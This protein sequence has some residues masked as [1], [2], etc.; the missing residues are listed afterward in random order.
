MKKA[1]LLTTVFLAVFW[2]S[3][4][5]KKETSDAGYIP[6]TITDVLLRKHTAA[7]T[8][9]LLKAEALGPSVSIAITTGSRIICAGTSVTFTATPSG[10]GPQVLYQWKKN[11]ITVGTTIATYSDAI[12]ADGDVITCRMYDRS[13]S[14]TT[15]S[16]P[17]TMSVNA[18]V[19]PT[20]TIAA[21]P[22]NTITSRTSVTFTATP[23]NGGTPVYQ[24]KKN[25]TNVGTNSATYTDATLA[26]NDVI[27]C[28]LT[29]NAD[30]IAPTVANSTPIQMVVTVTPNVTIAA[31][32]TLICVGTSVTFTATPTNGGASPSYQWKKNGLNVGTNSLTY[33]DATL[34]NIDVIRCVMTS[35]DPNASPISVTS[36]P[37][38]MIVNPSPTVNAIANRTVCVGDTTSM[39][40]LSGS[41][42]QYNWTNS[43]PNIGLAAT[44]TGSIASFTAVNS[45]N[46]PITATITVTP[47]RNNLI[48]YAYIANYNANTVSVINTTLNTVVATIPVGTNPHGV[49][50]SPNNQ[51][52][53]VANHGSNT[54][55]VIDAATNTILTT[56]PVSPNPF[57]LAFSPTGAFLYVSNE[58]GGGWVSVI[59][60]VSHAVVESFNIAG[61]RGIA[62]YLDDSHVYIV[63]DGWNGTISMLNRDANLI[64]SIWL[65]APSGDNDAI[66]P[67]DLVSHPNRNLIYVSA[68]LENAVYIVD[69]TTNLPIGSIPMGI[70]PLGLSLNANGS[71]LYVTNYQSNNVSVLNT[72]TNT[73]VSTIPVG[74]NPH[75]ISVSA[76]GRYIYVVNEGS[77]NVSVIDTATY[78]VVSTIAVGIKPAS[79]G[80]F[81][82]AN[83]STCEGS[84]T[85]FSIT[86]QPLPNATIS[87]ATPTTFCQGGNVVLNANAGNGLSYQWNQNGNAIAA[88]ANAAMFTATNTGSYTVVVTDANACMNTSNPT[89]VIVNTLPNTTI[90]HATPTTFCQGGNVVL[91][92]PSTAGLT[93]QWRNNG[94]ALNLTDRSY[95]AT[96][97]GA[98]SVSVTDA[99]NCTTTSPATTVVVNPMPTPVLSAS[100]NRTFC[101]GD[102]V[103]LQ[104]SGGVNYQWSH[105]T[106]D[107][108]IWLKNTGIYTVTVANQWGCS[109]SIAQQITVKPL[110]IA[111]SSASGA[112]TFCQGEQVVLN[113]NIGAGL[114]YQW[115]RNGTLI[116]NATNPN[117]TA[118]STGLYTVVV[119]GLN[120]CNNTSIPNSV[121]LNALPTATITP[122]SATTFCQ[123]GNVVLNANS[124]T[125]LRYQ[126]RNNGTPING[127]TNANYTTS[128]AGSYTVF[129]TNS[130]NC[131]S[132]SAAN[133]LIINELP[134]ASIMNATNILCNGDKSTLTVGGTGGL[135]P[136]QYN[137]NGGTY[138]NSNLFELSAGTFNVNVRD[139]NG[140]TS[141]NTALTLT[142]PNVLTIATP[143]AVP[144]NCYDGFTDLQS[145]ANGGTTPYQYSLTGF[146]F[147]NPNQFSV[148]GGT[149]QMVVRDA[150]G[151]RATSPL[152]NVAR[153]ADLVLTTATNPIKCWGDT[154]HSMI[155]VANAVSP[156]QYTVN[157]ISQNNNLYKGLQM[158]NYSVGVVDSRGCTKTTTFTI[159]Q[160]SLLTGNVQVDTMICKGKLTPLVVTA[161]GGTGN[162][163][164]RLNAGAFQNNT[165]M[166][167]AG[168]QK[169]QIRDANQCLHTLPTVMVE[170]ATAKMGELRNLKINCHEMEMRIYP[171]PVVDVMSVDFKIAQ[172]GVVKVLVYNALGD[173]IAHEDYKNIEAGSYTASWDTANWASDMVRVCL[174]VDGV[175]VQVTSVMIVH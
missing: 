142:Q 36:L 45:T 40:A 20:V 107:S 148:Q 128:T 127:A 171:N 130:N 99:N 159:T 90:T 62:A 118:N 61:A 77:N 150:N 37:I 155:Q 165:F 67:Y 35:N 83:R 7:T 138:Q 84:S 101:Q 141:L 117:Y 53:Y 154:T 173:L 26:M 116:P 2:Q 14:F 147:Q 28:E 15:T 89:S 140:C 162:I 123:G 75:G 143:T 166:V 168:E 108:S 151:C 38:T 152:Y 65:G 18:I 24:W 96:A 5:A 124:G 73:V 161:T 30:C 51:F 149:Y 57:K 1:F 25:N 93:Y 70:Q 115:Q 174:E 52:V 95:V 13:N 63:N 153:P 72:V 157:G 94:N 71:R 133:T 114:T 59:E 78:T 146:V 66:G 125:G 88:N 12:L 129:V 156:I 46:A 19:A 54:V 134:I 97:S 139:N 92:A 85:T 60:T 131:S 29:S 105:G 169:V 82:R 158:G 31:S 27:T 21:S 33:T 81:I 48:E 79:L 44:G 10:V 41:G 86:I 4:S 16:S 106:T 58:G 55:S 104:I 164:Y 91:N 102:S 3:A 43:N 87:N 39:I 56:I 32:N 8:T 98:Y 50:V 144:L 47:I 132:T 76:D 109:A 145:T 103:Q 110:P 42:T 136:Y 167:G 68:Y 111:T 121:I 135:A 49:A 34:A 100:G 175:C 69:A 119:T 112:T 23:T 17:I 122:A 80:N 160:P 172:S 126:W 120:A 11:G 163:S 9:R 74:L 137:A 113:A 170:D 22:S 6:K 64:Q